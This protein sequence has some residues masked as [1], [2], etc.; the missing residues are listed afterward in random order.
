MYFELKSDQ[1]EGIEDSLFNE[2]LDLIG[3][4]KYFISGGDDAWLK[5]DGNVIDDIPQE[6]F[7][8]VSSTDQTPNHVGKGITKMGYTMD[9]TSDFLP[10]DL[11]MEDIS[12]VVTQE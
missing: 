1:V 10:W 9:S 8:Y 2:F 12:Q 5:L 7:D 3:D 4:D 11:T 6:E